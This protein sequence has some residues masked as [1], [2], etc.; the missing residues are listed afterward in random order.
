MVYVGHFSFAEDDADSSV[1]DEPRHGYFT[2][3]VEA[4]DVE[5]ALEKFR[6][7]IYRLHCE[8]DILERISDVFLDACVECRA[9]PDSGFLAH[10]MEW[11]G[12]A[13]GSISTAIRG[14]EDEQAAAYY[15]T[16]E[17]LKDPDDEHYVEPF[18]SFD[19]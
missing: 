9:I 11:S 12:R 2:A 3:V 6:T 5:D 1:G 15:I 18:V 16:P 17:D 8:E 14:A 10:L 19:R 4:K 13:R 7:L